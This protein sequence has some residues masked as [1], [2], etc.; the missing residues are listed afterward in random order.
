MARNYVALFICT[1]AVF[2]AL[3]AGVWGPRGFAVN[4]QLAS[5][6]ADVQLA[7]DLERLETQNL[8]DR[9][10]SVWDTDELLD[11]ARVMGYVERGQT[12]YFFLGEDGK[13][14][15]KAPSLP[16]SEGGAAGSDA[17]GRLRSFAGLSRRASMLIGTALASLVTAGT[18]IAMHRR[19]T[20]VTIKREGRNTH[21]HDPGQV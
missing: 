14:L 20:T 18:W 10:E 17:K 11:D 4:A 12:V 8:R 3:V 2:T 16:G 7:Y 13:L 1:T 5:Q 6:V 9:L 19:K 15:A 21:V